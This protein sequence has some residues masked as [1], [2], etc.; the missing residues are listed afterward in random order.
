MAAA[1]VIA[2]ASGGAMASDVQKVAFSYK[3]SDLETSDG[4][5]SVY[6]RIERAAQRQCVS[7]RAQG[8]IPAHAFPDCKRDVEMSLVK[9]I[10]H[11]GLLAMAGERQNVASRN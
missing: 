4:V 7:E 10:G 9:Q 3:A 1:V 11:P 8:Q 6:T 2:F 5:A